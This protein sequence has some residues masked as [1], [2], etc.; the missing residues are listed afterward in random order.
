MPTSYLNLCCLGCSCVINRRTSEKI[1]ANVID[2]CAYD[3][4]FVLVKYRKC[5]LSFQWR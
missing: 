3:V 1:K 5:S 2:A 4:V